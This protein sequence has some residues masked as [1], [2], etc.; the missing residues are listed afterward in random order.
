[1]VMLNYLN[2]SRNHLVGSIPWPISSM[3]MQSLTYV[4]FSYNNLSRS[5]TSPYKDEDGAANGAHQPHFKGAL[6]WL[7]KILLLFALPCI[8][9]LRVA[10]LNQGNG[11]QAKWTLKFVSLFF[12]RRA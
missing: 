10:I 6:S 5:G 11:E 9:A 1:M 4:D 7:L 8:I 2:L 3:H 12:N